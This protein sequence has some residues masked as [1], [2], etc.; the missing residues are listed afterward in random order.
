MSLGPRATGRR[1]GQ[2]TASEASPRTAEVT[3]DLVLP[4]GLVESGQATAR[5]RGHD[6]PTAAT[7]CAEVRSVMGPAVPLQSGWS[8]HCLQVVERASTT[9]HPCRTQHKSKSAGPRSPRSR[10]LPSPH[11]QRDAF[12]LAPDTQMI[13]HCAVHTPPAIRDPRRVKPVTSC[14]SPST[15]T[16]AAAHRFPQVSELLKLG[17]PLDCPSKAGHSPVHCSNY[18]LDLCGAK[19]TR[20][21]GLLH[22]MKHQHGP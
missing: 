16:E 8:G 20:T 5:T 19:G 10:R 18:V 7:R 4:L 13:L 9:L 14:S 2:R 15:A 11:R 21:P 6:R 22:A 17:L 3:A 1:V 12:A